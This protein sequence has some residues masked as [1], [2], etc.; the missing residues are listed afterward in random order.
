MTKK[1]GKAQKNP[2]KYKKSYSSKS[3]CLQMQMLAKK[4][5][6]FK[7]HIVADANASQKVQNFNKL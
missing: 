4:L 1:A 3:R 6:K 5:K 2:K 7:E